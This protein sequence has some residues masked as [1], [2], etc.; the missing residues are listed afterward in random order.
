VDRAPYLSKA[1]YDDALDVQAAQQQLRALR[2]Q[3]KTLQERAGQGTAL[4]SLTTFDQKAAGLEGGSGGF[5]GFGGGGGG[6]GGGGG[7]DTL[8]GIGGSLSSLMGLLQGAD[9]APTS[10]LLAAVEDSRKALASLMARW[11][12][13]KGED[14]SK[15]NELLKQANL[16]PVALNP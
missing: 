5:G 10:Q 7:L 8:A 12:A 4:Q 9:V 15:L 13:L 3:V 11:N 1:L 14:L 2:A 16:P 6:R